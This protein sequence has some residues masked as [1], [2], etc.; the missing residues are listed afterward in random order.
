[1][2]LPSSS[3]LNAYHV[4]GSGNPWLLTTRG[5][6]ADSPQW[7]QISCGDEF[8]ALL[9]KE[10]KVFTMG[11]NCKGQLGHGDTEKRDFPTQVAALEEYVIIQIA[12]GPDHMAALTDKGAVFTWYVP[13]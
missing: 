5:N 2:N 9:T 10:G 7:A 8:T 1:M 4:D 11:N 6:T 13:S 3:S 12:C